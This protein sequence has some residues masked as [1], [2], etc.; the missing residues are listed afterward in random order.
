ME[1][2]NNKKLKELKEMAR[3]Y[4]IK[5]RSKMRKQELIE[6]LNQI[7]LKPKLP[8][9]LIKPNSRKKKFNLKK[10]KVLD[11]LFEKLQIEFES[12]KN[13]EVEEKMRDV[14]SE[15]ENEVSKYKKKGGLKENLKNTSYAYQMF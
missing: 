2:V 6:A 9:N 4:K 13:E 3:K 12:E 8:S 10:I 14:E 15:L 5:G 1:Q 11:K 7:L